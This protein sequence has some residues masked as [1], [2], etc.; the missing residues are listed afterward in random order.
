MTLSPERDKLSRGEGGISI[1]VEDKVEK[2]VKKENTQE[3]IEEV[4]MNF[5]LE[6]PNKHDDLA[7][8]HDLEEQDRNKEQSTTLTNP[9]VEKT[10]SLT[11]LTF[12]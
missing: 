2:L 10:G 7:T 12:C 3:G 6:K 8:N 9:K 4:K 1:K 5:D 11:F